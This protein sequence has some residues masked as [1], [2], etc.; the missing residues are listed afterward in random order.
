M[1]RLYLGATNNSYIEIPSNQID[2]FERDTSQPPAPVP[3]ETQASTPLNLQRQAS[4]SAAGLDQIVSSAGERHKLDPDFIRSVIKAESGFH[5]NAISS[6]GALGLMQL[7]PRTASEL[8]VTNPFN[9]N[10]NVDGGTRYLRDL[11][12]KYNFD[13]NKALAAYNAGPKRVDQYHG[14]PPY[15]ETQAYI[16]RII[17]DFN[18]QKIAKNP[19]LAR[20][21]AAPARK[22]AAQNRPAAARA[23]ART[24]GRAQVQSSSGTPSISKGPETASR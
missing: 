10:A 12:E 9:P 21:Q 14:V 3:L 11:L 20:Q 23:S 2:H 19:A 4:L 17:R 16:S 6:K 7:M 18:R 8:G 1:T 13:V 24:S 5:Q 15:N 22:H